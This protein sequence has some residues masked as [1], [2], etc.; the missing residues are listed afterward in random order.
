MSNDKSSYANS[1]QIKV[2][3]LFLDLAINF[4][5]KTLTGYADLTLNAVV[6]G[7]DTLILDSNHLAVGQVKNLTSGTDLFF[8]FSD[9]IP[10]FGRKF[11]IK[12]ENPLKV[13][14]T[15]TIRIYY[16]T[17]PESTALQWLDPAQTQ[18]KVHPYLF[19]QCEE[20]HCRSLCPIQDSP[21]VKFSYKARISVVAPL[22]VLMSAI[23][24]KETAENGIN[25]F[26]Y[27]QKVPIP[28]YLLALAAGNLVYRDISKR[29]RVYCEEASIKECEF[30][31]EPTEKYL[32]TA[33]EFLTPYEWERYDLLVLPGSFPFGG[34]ENPCLTFCSPTI[35]AGDRTLTDVVIHEITHS[36]IGN[37]VT[38]KNW[39]H[40][41]LNEGINV[42]SERCISRILN[43]EEYFQISA[44]EG[45]KG[46]ETYV[47]NLGEHHPFTVMVTN[48]EGI[49]PD[50]AYSILYYEKGFCLM[51][52]MEGL[53]G[54]DFMQEFLRSYIKKFRL[55]SIDTQTFYEHLKEKLQEKYPIDHVQQLKL[56]DW[57]AWTKNTGH[58]PQTPVYNPDVNEEPHFMAQKMVDDAVKGDGWE[59][60]DVIK[61]WHTL[62]YK[63]F[64]EKLNNIVETRHV[65]FSEKYMDHLDLVYNFS[66]K[67][68]EIRTDWFVLCIK[69]EFHKVNSH[70]AE[71][72]SNY[73]RM[74]F[75]RPIYGELKKQGRTEFAWEIYNKSKT[76]YHS[77]AAKV[78]KNLLSK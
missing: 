37:L 11:T 46:L 61:K 48:L 42:Y 52:Y 49:D 31:M 14:D 69:Q 35:L 45:L 62:K 17:T 78:L 33:E 77:I 75:L 60:Y 68:A 6:S 1:H 71:F 59:S 41:W 20:I 34:M 67:N 73:G 10:V 5:T 27:E 21:A 47:K 26:Y 66:K 18:G 74:K 51:Y 70:I 24:S 22:R 44:Q 19:S 8:S 65:K 3:N 32:A 50:D 36:W 57:D 40:F 7:V 55:Q 4:D 15:Q 9:A 16:S 25:V 64:F 12:L 43:G 13:N 63:L 29:C 28:A 38:N 39:E 58:I 54:K 2:S 76:F 53:F 30:E 72:L 23:L 56:I